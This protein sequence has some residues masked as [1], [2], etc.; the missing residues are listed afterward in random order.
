M[1]FHMSNYSIESLPEEVLVE[2]FKFLDQNDLKQVALTC[3]K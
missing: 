1:S 2:I 3:K